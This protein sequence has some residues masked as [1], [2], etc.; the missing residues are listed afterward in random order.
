MGKLN[1]KQKD[2]IYFFESMAHSDNF[3]Q[4][5]L[6]SLA[7]LF[8]LE[9]STF[10][11]IDSD[12]RLFEPVAFNVESGTITS[13]LEYYQDKD[14][15]HPHNLPHKKYLQNPIL[16]ITDVMSLKNFEQTEYYN[17]FLKVQGFYHEIIINLT[18]KG[19][20]LGGIGLYKPK[21]ESFSLATKNQLKL[22]ARFLEGQLSKHL[23]LQKA[24]VDQQIF[25]YSMNENPIGIILFDKNLSVL[26]SNNAANDMVAALLHKRLNLDQF[27]KHAVSLTGILSNPSR[28]SSLSL[29]SPS[30]KEFTIRIKPVSKSLDLDRR[31]FLMELIPEDFLSK[32]NAGLNKAVSENIK[33]K[34]DLTER[35]LQVLGLI[36]QGLTNNKAA[37][38]LFISPNTVKAHLRSILKKT[39]T[40]NRIKLYHIISGERKL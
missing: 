39:G 12:L 23:A 36:M 22:L 8:N 20:L 4:Q 2:F 5:A 15:F 14:I 19:K 10:F 25:Q 37:Q 29:Y 40:D 30:L 9:H 34:Y 33:K 3:R 18:E 32:G 6:F 13:Y 28:A 7:E 38:I 26:F 17:D 24:L 27:V 16:D 35:E 1:K 31:T 11:L 21:K